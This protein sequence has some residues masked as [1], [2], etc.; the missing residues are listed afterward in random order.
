MTTCDFGCGQ[1]AIHTFK[2]SKKNC[3]SISVNSCPEMKR[4]NSLSKIDYH[5]FRGKQHPRGMLG[6]PGKNQFTK[7]KELGE[8]YVVSHETRLKISNS[9]KNKKHSEETKHKISV[10]T[11]ARHLAGWAPQCGRAKKYDYVSSKAGKISVDGTWELLVAK[12]LDS[13]NVTWNRNKNKFVYTHLNGK[14]STYTPDFYVKEWD[15]YIE[16]KGYETELDKCKWKQFPH[17]LLVWKKEKINEIKNM[18]V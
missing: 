10:A 16:V 14:E 1:P 13:L 17:K 2:T 15:A 11:K 18:E 3:C 5:P 9:S 7:A 4:K 8:V 12:Y 6:K